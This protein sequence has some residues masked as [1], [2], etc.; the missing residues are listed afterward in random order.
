MIIRSTIFFLFFIQWGL[1]VGIIFM[2]LLISKRTSL[3][4][5]KLWAQG[6]KLSSKYILKINLEIN[7]KK[8]ITTSPNIIAAQHQSSF[9]TYILFLLFEK[10]I[11]IVKKS[12]MLELVKCKPIRPKLCC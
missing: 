9:E 3:W 10:P 6:I 7:G 4:T 1:L 11:F 12:T 5:I 8:N 2:P